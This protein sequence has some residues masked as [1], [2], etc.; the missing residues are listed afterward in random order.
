VNG[1]GRVGLRRAFMQAG[2]PRVVSTL[3]KIEDEA[4]S[5]LM[6]YFYDSLLKKNKPPSA[7]LRD[8]QVRILKDRRWENPYFWAS[9]VLTG[10]WR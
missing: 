2:V 7:A 6:S 8:A 10:D 1:E 3:W 9:F 4:T 5:E